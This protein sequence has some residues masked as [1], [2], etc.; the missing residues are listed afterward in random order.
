MCV[1]QYVNAQTDVI[2]NFRVLS[3]LYIKGKFACEFSGQYIMAM[4][5]PYSSGQ[6][7]RDVISDNNRII[8]VLSR[9][10]IP[11]GFGDASI[12][13]VCRRSG[14]D[15]ATFLAVA[16]L[17]AGKRYDHLEISLPA[18]TGYLRR[19][20]VRFLEFL[21]PGIKRMLIDGLQRESTSDVDLVILQFFDEYLEEVR[22]HMAFEDSVIFRHVEQLCEGRQSDS[23][24][25]SDFSTH[26]DNMAGKL[27]D[28]VELFIY[29][30]EQRNNER[31][32]TALLQLMRI[33]KDLTEHCE[34]ENRLLFPAIA[35]LE[36]EL[37]S[38][39]SVM[40]GEDVHKGET[41]ILS[42]R[43]KDV[44]REIARGLSTKEIAHVLCLSHHTVTTHRK[45]IAE[46]LNIHSAAAM[47]VYA[48]LHHI[49][50]IKE[51]EK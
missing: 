33:G 48:I 46:K 30:Y 6:S 10:D 16:N 37:V 21:L 26:H 11:L 17:I 24:A 28:L 44:L 36:R 1:G 4:Q 47:A 32:S 39:E 13:E 31:L 41:Q 19:S 20:H 18:I 27:T 42:E 8:M 34:I 29:K 9:F 40:S 14:V 50:D 25:I 2:T 22:E 43:E 35:K 3:I 23:F 15:T 5:K 49:I 12:D 38:T 45:N 51:I 7:L